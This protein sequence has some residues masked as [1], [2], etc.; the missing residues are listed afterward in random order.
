M[1]R[2]VAAVFAAASLSAF[3]FSATA[4]PVQSNQHVVLA[5]AQ[6][7]TAS[8]PEQLDMDAVPSLTVDGIRQ[9]QQALAKKGFDPGP[10]DGVLGPQTEQAIRKFQDH[11]GL[12]VTG[13]IDNQTLYAL[14][15]AQLAGQA[16]Q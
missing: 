5:Q 10:I 16:R 8:N 13:R 2:F 3:G 14:G 4:Q 9:V 1:W 7:S 12:K 6:S 11:Y 15:E